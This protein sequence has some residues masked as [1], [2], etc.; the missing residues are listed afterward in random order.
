MNIVSALL[1]F[2]GTFLLLRIYLLEF[3]RLRFWKLVDLFQDEFFKI[4]DENE[5]WVYSRSSLSKPSDDYAGP[6][7]I[8]RG[9]DTFTVFAL[10]DSI[11]ESQHRF[12]KIFGPQIHKKPFP[13][14]SFIAMIYP[15]SSMIFHPE[16]IPI[17]YPWGSERV[18]TDPTGF[19]ILGYGFVNLSYL[20]FVAGILRGSFRILELD[21]RVQ[22]FSAAVIFGVLGLLLFNI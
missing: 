19:S 12:I 3:G 8:H 13:K 15:L 18:F 1:M 16:K 21:A 17:L 20:L 9:G 6:F 7:F 2:I 10:K 5:T 14:I 4:M 22:V 11:K